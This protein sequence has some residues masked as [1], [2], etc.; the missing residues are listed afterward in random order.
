MD[1]AGM[2]PLWC[3]VALGL[4]Y[5][6]ALP[7]A[8]PSLFASCICVDTFGAMHSWIPWVCVWPVCV[9]TVL[10]AGASASIAAASFP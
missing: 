4:M 9:V 2:L 7:V 6:V 1:G 5:A 10:I 3:G 8:L